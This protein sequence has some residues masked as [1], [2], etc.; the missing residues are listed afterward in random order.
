ME[1]K[2]SV[3]YLIRLNPIP[4]DVKAR[5]NRKEHYR[6]QHKSR[7]DNLCEISYLYEGSLSEIRQNR[8]ITFP[9]GSV[10][11]NLFTR[12]HEKYTN[13]PVMH[14]FYLLFKLSEP[15]R[16]LTEDEVANWSNK[17]HYAILPECITDTAACEHI[18]G[19]LK[20]AANTVR[21]GM[22]VRSLKLRSIMYE[23]LAILTEQAI[24]QA[25]EHLQ[26]TVRN[27]RPFTKKAIQYIEQHLA[28]KL[29]VS[30]IAEHA[31]V[32]YTYLNRVFHQDTGMSMLEFA[33]RRRIREVEKYITDDGMTMEQAGDKVGI[34]DIKYL[35]RL[36]HRYVGVSAAEYRHLYHAR[37]I[38][39]PDT[40]HKNTAA[41]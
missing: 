25:R 19:L 13:C 20:T 11:T 39:P 38:F 34:S 26:R 28:E 14:E 12:D 3:Y 30:Q 6:W 2:P 21:T 8:E 40:G 36:F 18:G 15:P 41:K 24:L 4:R 22:M 16:L 5:Q 33:N 31:G 7:S 29:Q 35:S 1:E 10:Y 27:T 32:S 23:C 37:K 9:Q 17:V